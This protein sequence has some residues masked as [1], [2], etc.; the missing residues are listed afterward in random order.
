MEKSGLIEL[1]RRFRTLLAVPRNRPTS[2]KKGDLR[3]ALGLQLRKDWK[4]WEGE[5]GLISP[6]M[7]LEFLASAGPTAAR[8]LSD[9]G[10]IGMI[11]FL[12][13]RHKSGSD[14]DDPE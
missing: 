12:A 11:A 3:A 5:K 1:G 10:L 13:V 8:S 4:T 6:R 7:V 9:D 2:K 14:R